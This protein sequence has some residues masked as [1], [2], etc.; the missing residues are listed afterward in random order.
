MF[1]GKPVEPHKAHMGWS[2]AHLGGNL[3]SRLGIADKGAPSH[4]RGRA[5]GSQRP[6]LPTALCLSPLSKILGLR[7]VDP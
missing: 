4:P 7:P 3:T 2:A 6:P 5:G 1:G